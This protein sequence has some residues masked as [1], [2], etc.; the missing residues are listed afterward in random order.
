[1]RIQLLAD[2][3]YIDSFSKYL[4]GISGIELVPKDGEVV[5]DLRFLDPAKKLVEIPQ[6]SVLI[7][8][9]LTHSATAVH[10]A[11]GKDVRVIGF[12]VFPQYFERQ[13]TIEYS[14]PLGGEKNDTLTEVLSQL[15]KTGEEIN[16][17]V[18]GVFPRALAMVI[19]EA[20]FA[21]Q[22]GVALSEDI[23]TAMKLGTNYPKGPLAWCD[24]IG[25]EAI[26]AVLDA[27]AREYGSD[28]YRVAAILRRHAE[29]G[30]TFL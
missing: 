14:F 11:A 8:N 21:V 5:L 4:T 7:T 12:P 10:S 1:L 15:G 30:A 3:Q 29:S 20:A 17:A 18:A 19:N 2:N 28:R 16:D 22:E 23:D 24:E 27:L 13:K 6:G 9:T 26:V 25:A